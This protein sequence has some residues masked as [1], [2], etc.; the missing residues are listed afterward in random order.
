MNLYTNC[1]GWRNFLKIVEMTGTQV[2]SMDVQNISVKAV[3][4]GVRID[5]AREG[6]ICQVFTTEG[7]QVKT[8]TIRETSSFVSLPEGQVYIVKVGGKTLKV[9]L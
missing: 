5:N 4:G 9:A 8:V 2:A 1:N 3:K 6:S 7:K